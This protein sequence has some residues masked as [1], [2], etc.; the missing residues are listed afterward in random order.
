M[1]KGEM[2]KKNAVLYPTDNQNVAG[3]FPSA[4]KT[5]LSLRQRK[6]HKRSVLVAGIRAG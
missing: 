1:R 4:I 2:R 5:S 3:V 6:N